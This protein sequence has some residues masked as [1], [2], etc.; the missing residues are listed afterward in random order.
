MQE[1]AI[2]NIE[3]GLEIPVAILKLILGDPTG[4]HDKWRQ[5]FANSPEGGSKMFAENLGTKNTVVPLF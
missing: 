1:V 4:L 3:E 5:P 2:L